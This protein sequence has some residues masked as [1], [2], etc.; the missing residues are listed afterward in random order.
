MIYSNKSSKQA[1]K[2]EASDRLVDDFDDM[3]MNGETSSFSSMMFDIG[4]CV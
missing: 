4:R 2:C 3:I 1:M